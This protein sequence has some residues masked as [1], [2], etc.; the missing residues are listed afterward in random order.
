VNDVAIKDLPKFLVANPTD[1][2]HELT[3]NDPDNPL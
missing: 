1:Q 3:I 2:T